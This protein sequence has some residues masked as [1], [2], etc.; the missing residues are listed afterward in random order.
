MIFLDRVGGGGR[1]KSSLVITRPVPVSAGAWGA[2]VVFLREVS[3]AGP[4]A[5]DTGRYDESEPLFEG[6]E[7]L[8]LA[9]SASWRAVGGRLNVGA[10]LC[11][12]SF[13]R[14]SLDEP[15]VG[16]GLGRGIVIAVLVRAEAS[17]GKSFE[18]R[19]AKNSFSA[20]E[21]MVGNPV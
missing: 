16:G 12:P 2:A 1:V 10:E 18:G 9:R 20:Y 5:G 21:A 17:G 13:P 4:T 11:M 3:P 19:R 8:T 7:E 15:G 14:R 6:V